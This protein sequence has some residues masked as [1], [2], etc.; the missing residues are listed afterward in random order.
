[1]DGDDYFFA[2]LFGACVFV[3]VFSMLILGINKSDREE[4]R[5]QDR[6]HEK[7]ITNGNTWIEETCIPGPKK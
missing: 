3:F 4:E 2:F 7:C 1:M 5:K 6:I